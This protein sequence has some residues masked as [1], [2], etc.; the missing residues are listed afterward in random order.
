[1]QTLVFDQNLS[2]VRANLPAVNLQG[3]SIDGNYSP[4]GLPLLY[5]VEDETVAR[6][7]VT[8]QEYLLAHWKLDE[9][10]YS[11]APDAQGSYHGTLVDLVSTG[12]FNSWTK[13]IFSNGL[14]LGVLAEGL[15]LGACLS[16]APLLFRFG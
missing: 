5:S 9:E 7:K 11:S 4:T 1:M 15:S 16:R 8:R 3:Y 12:P 14:D 2:S 10:L 13:G 6:L